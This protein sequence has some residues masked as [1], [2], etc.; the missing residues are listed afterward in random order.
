[1]LKHL[2]V[3]L[4]LCFF[5][6]CG[7]GKSSSE[8]STDNI[9]SSNSGDK[10]GSSC[11]KFIDKIVSCCKLSIS[12]DER[13]SAIKECEDEYNDL[14]SEEK[15]EVDKMVDKLTCSDIA[16]LAAEEGYECG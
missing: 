6:S 5:V 8:S 13:K 11:Q 7:D 1:M 10:T 9:G 4:A 15:K 14:S 3:L 2:L 16:Q 12:S